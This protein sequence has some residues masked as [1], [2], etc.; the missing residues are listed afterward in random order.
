MRCPWPQVRSPDAVALHGRVYA[1][2]GTATDAT[3]L[4]RVEQSRARVGPQTRSRPEHLTTRVRGARCCFSK[5]ND[6]HQSELCVIDDYRLV[7]CDATWDPLAAPS[8]FKNA[9]TRGAR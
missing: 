9:L 7:W 5:S 1:I 3:A 2:G 6:G 8:R 4:R